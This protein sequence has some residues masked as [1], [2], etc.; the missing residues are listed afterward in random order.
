M[1]RSDSSTVCWMGSGK[2]KRAE[3]RG[4]GGQQLA[5]SGLIFACACAFAFLVSCAGK[6]ASS[7]LVAL[8]QVD[9]IIDQGQGA[10]GLAKGFD[11]LYKLARDSTEWMSIA[12]RSLRA[13]A[14][15]DRGRGAATAETSLRAFPANEEIAAAAGWLFLRDGQG[16]RAFKL[17]PSP[18]RPESHLDLWAEARLSIRGAHPIVDQ[19]DCRKLAVA[20]GDPSWYIDAALLA[21]R[22]GN[23]FAA[24]AWLRKAIGEGQ[25][26]A[27]SVLWDAGMTGEILDSLGPNPSPNDAVLGADAAWLEGDKSRALTL[28]NGARMGGSGSSWRTEAAIAV[29]QPTGETAVASARALAEGNAS[30][31]EALRYA[32]AILLREGE[33][34]EAAALAPALER[35]S[36]LLPEALGLEFDSRRQ[37]EGRFIAR[38]IR[39]AEEHRDDPRAREFA[40]RVLLAHGRWD[41]YLVIH[42]GASPTDRADLRWW[43][44]A[45]TADILRGDYADADSKARD[46]ASNY[47][48]D[49]PE[50]A[51]AQ[52]LSAS[53][54]GNDAA[55]QSL[56]GTALTLSLNGHQRAA[57]LKELG[58]LAARA[59]KKADAIAAFNAAETADPGDVEARV[60]ASSMAR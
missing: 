58:R 24:Q 39:L 55:A 5:A 49:G 15:G 21:M 56:F 11:R 2:P 6:D 45:M 47:R 25:S 51:F 9:A 22:S 28:W 4:L 33:S 59:G 37:G 35:K 16:E 18:L 8:S 27:I 50:A 19:E 23:R 10:E 1:T 52:G 38:S 43:F 54:V 20:S 7:F 31:P 44:W 53:L 26:P 32:A 48:E 57:A 60:L 36:I 13:E 14:L 34:A 29:L 12:K 3:T 41:E 17:F 30:E 40:L 42:D 46:G